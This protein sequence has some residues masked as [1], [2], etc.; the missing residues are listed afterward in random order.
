MRAVCADVLALMLPNDPWMKPF[1]PS[2]IDG[3]ISNGMPWLMG[4]LLRLDA[5]R[6]G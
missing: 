5:E 2:L 4:E 1:I 6:R 3:Y